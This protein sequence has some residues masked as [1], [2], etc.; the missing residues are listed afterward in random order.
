MPKRYRFFGLWPQDDTSLDVLA[1]A[2]GLGA[3]LAVGTASL[4]LALVGAAL[5]FLAVAARPWI[6]IPTIVFSL[7]FYLHPRPIAGLE[8]SATE[9]AILIAT[10]SVL[11]RAA[12]EF[13]TARR[14]R[15][16]PGPQ[17]PTPLRP[18]APS[19]VDWGAASF[20]LAGLLSMLVTE[21]PR[22]SFREL[23]WLIVEPLLV[24]YVARAT[25]G[26]PGHVTAT[27]WSIMLAGVLA[28]ALGV[29]TSISGGADPLARATAPYLSPNHLGL[30]LGRAG[31]IALALALFGP[32]RRTRLPTSASWGSLAMI[33]VGLI[34]TLSLG[35]W[36]GFG[37][38]AL[39]LAW[40]RG[41]RWSAAAAL[42][43]VGIAVVALLALPPDRTTAR[44]DP[45]TG[46][47]LVRVQIWQASLRMLADHPLLGVG[48][49]NFLYAYRGRYILPEASEE[50]NISHPHNWV[51]HFWLQLG[52][53]GLAAAIALM[54]WAAVSALQLFRTP[55][56]A[57]DRPL[58]AAT[59]GMLVDF[60]MHGAFDNSY[61]L[62]DMAV[63]WWI[64]LGLLAV[65]LSALRPLAPGPEPALTSGVDNG[66]VE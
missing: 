16:H 30:F 55:G 23:R 20:L 63:I 37:A 13:T 48:L 8:F 1:L 52:L 10:T 38:A 43:L 4:L 7:P 51:L 40:L 50:P 12:L 46:T 36:L 5:Y 47:A 49:D 66:N 65:R 14:Q 57:I 39:A 45:Q 62:V 54:V 32:R 22:Q 15:P 64:M 58:A 9:I 53:L 44:L 42:F 56:A 18:L 60:L 61:F 21:Y 41:R 27:L 3:L 28:A 35:A 2:V 19:V 24:F 31:T 34:K 17:R 29:A 25:L 26:N 59:A 33:G 6:A 11:G